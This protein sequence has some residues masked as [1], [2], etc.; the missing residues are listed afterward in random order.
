MKIK[1]IRGATMIEVLTASFMT[2]M[3][4]TT[5]VATMLYGLSSWAKG[6]GRIYAETDSQKAIRLISMELREAMS[7]IV[8]GDGLGLSYRRPQLDVNGNYITPAVW[9]NVNRRI[10][11]SGSTLRIVTDGQARTICTGVVL[12]DPLTSGGTGTYRVFQAPAGAITRQITVQVVTR[13][14]TY[15]TMQSYSRSRETIFL[16]NVPELSK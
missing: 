9:D 1:R 7:V 5:A 12:T 10:E 13:R 14:N 2:V 3:V 11:L 16:R 6:Q 15:K 8:D 4:V